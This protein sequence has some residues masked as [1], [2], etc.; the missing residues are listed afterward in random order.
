MGRKV[1][2]GQLS[3][4]RVVSNDCD[5]LFEWANDQQTRENSHNK[6]PVI[7][8][9]HVI[10]LDKK[11]AASDSWMFIFLLDNQPVAVLRLDKKRTM[12]LSVIP[13]RLNTGKKVLVRKLSICCLK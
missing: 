9:N 13:L 10:W 3:Y 12:R 4:R 6:E 2:V 8:E 11:L 5:L 1:K 7:Y